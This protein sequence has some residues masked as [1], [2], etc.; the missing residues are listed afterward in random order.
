MEFEWDVDKAEANKKKHGVS[1]EDA[2]LVFTDPNAIT[3]SDPDHSIAEAR[4]ITIG[5]SNKWLILLVSHTERSGR[6]R[7]ISARKATK[8]ETKLYE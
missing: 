4:E 3:F 2:V 5:K 6:I 8:S 7:I 1:F